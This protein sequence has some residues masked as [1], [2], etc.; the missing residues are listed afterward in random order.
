MQ[1]VALAE[2]AK[3]EFEREWIKGINLVTDP[4]ASS[5][6]RLNGRRMS[7]LRKAVGLLSKMKSRL[8]IG[9]GAPGKGIECSKTK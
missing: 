7:L 4:S 2:E 5:S 6:G 3:V 1:K 9:W 8:L